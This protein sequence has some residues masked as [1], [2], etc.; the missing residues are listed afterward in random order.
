MSPETALMA[1]VVLVGLAIVPPGSYS[2]DGASMLAVSDSLLTDGSFSVPCDDVGVRGRGGACYSAWY[3]LLSI[4]MLPFAALGRALA[5][6]AGVAP[7]PVET[8]VALL[9]PVLA[10]AGAAGLTARMAREAGASTRAAVAAALGLVF[11]TELLT[12]SR[13]L[14]AEPLAAFLVALAAWGLLGAGRRRTIG[15]VAIA[16][17]VLAKPQMALAG[18]GIAAGLAWHRRDLRPLV[19]AGAATAAGVF[20]YML[21]NE[22]RF[23]DPLDFGGP[24]RSFAWAVG[25]FGGTEVRPLPERAVVGLGVLTVSP[26]NGLLL[27][28]PL[29]LLGAAGL[30]VRRRQAVAA[31]CL[32]GAAAVLAAYVL[33]P[34]G[35]NWGT[36]YLVPALPLLAVGIA[37]FRGRLAGL[38]V[39][40]AALTFVS[41]LP[42]LVAFYQR[43]Y[44]ER[45]PQ[46][47]AEGRITPEYDVWNPD[48]QLIGVWSSA[49]HQLED[50][51]HT[52][53]RALLESSSSAADDREDILRTVA[54]WWWMLPAV[55]IPAW[56]G[57]AFSLVLAACGLALFSVALRR[58]APP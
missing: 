53:P 11:G 51:Q 24:A 48:A 16:L 38:A 7:R 15:H 52:S 41:Q 50:A 55:G 19:L 45:A 26:Q 58:R 56:L 22:L 36:R 33:Q 10:T 9:V 34:Y 21:Y 20:A 49:A 39:V 23:A 29:A 47:R 42:D 27:Y 32:G 13:S 17:A 44:R 35:G 31:A 43:L 14:Y 37:T 30:A 28:S 46:A 54:L 18:L 12:Y 8:V 40:L 3:P 5:A 2:V 6:V 25:D 1:G 57:A 4:V